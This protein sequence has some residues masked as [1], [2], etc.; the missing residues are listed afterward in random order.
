VEIG[1]NGEI[2]V[3]HGYWRNVKTGI[4]VPVI[5][6]EQ[7]LENMGQHIGIR[8]IAKIQGLVINRVELGYDTPPPMMQVDEL[9]PAYE[10]EVLATFE[11]GS[12][13]ELWIYVPAT[14]T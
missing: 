13:E 14:S 2:V 6:P 10:I 8:N 3:F 11:D 1:D 9:S 4:S 12:E 7:A 5:L